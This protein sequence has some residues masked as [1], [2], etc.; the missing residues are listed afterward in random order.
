MAIANPRSGTGHGCPGVTGRR[1]DVAA[2]CAAVPLKWGAAVPV[3]GGGLSLGGRLRWKDRRF[4]FT[5]KVP[6]AP[7]HMSSKSKASRGIRNR[8]FKLNP[9]THAIRHALAIS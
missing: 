4:F 5:A 2:K 3:F 7:S 8:K 6:G 9:A 1:K